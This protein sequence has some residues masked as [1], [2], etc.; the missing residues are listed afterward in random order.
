VTT[1]SNLV[2]SIM[3][4]DS[5]YN[6]EGLSQDDCLSLFVKCAFKEGED[7]QNPNLLEIGKEIVKKC[8]GVPLAVR[9]LGSMLYS[10]VD[11]REW[12]FVRDNEIWK[13]EQKES[14]ILPAL[15]LSYDQ[16]PIH[17]KRCFAFCSLFPKD[18]E[19][20]S[21]HLIQMWMAH[22]LI[23][24]TS[25]NKKQELEDVGDLYIN[26]LLSRSFFQDVDEIILYSL[27]LPLKCM[28]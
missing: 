8:K 16:M 9:T 27:L 12:E 6:L 28:I 21:F 23:L 20:D 15:R 7:K 13:L 19:F 3:S 25:I 1:R 14:D 11:E 5:T 22:G 17:L 4:T 2:A 10:K 24:E 26:E 18:H